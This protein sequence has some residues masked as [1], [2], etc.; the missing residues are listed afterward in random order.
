MLLHAQAADDFRGCQFIGWRDFTNF[1]GTPGD[2]PDERILTS[3][4]ITTRIAWN[5]LVASW[6]AELPA[7][8]WLKVEARGLHDER[9]T[10]FYALGLWSDDPQKHPRES[11]KNQKDADGDVLTDTLVLQRPCQQFQLRVTLGSGLPARPP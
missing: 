6:N 4:P 3:P 1:T 5:E 2:R 7:D 9:A 11:V 8:T 10:K